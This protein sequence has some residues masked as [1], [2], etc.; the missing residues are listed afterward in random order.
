MVVKLEQPHIALHR[1]TLV[2]F[3]RA[4]LERLALDD[5]LPWIGFDNSTC[6]LFPLCSVLRSHR[7]IVYAARAM[8]PGPATHRTMLRR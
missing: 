8:F 4:V 3:F 7:R 5:E 6:H 2:K 1:A